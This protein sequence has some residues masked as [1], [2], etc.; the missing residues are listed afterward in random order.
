[1]D[2][3]SSHSIAT[4][5]ECFTGLCCKSN[6]FCLM[7]FFFFSTEET[8]FDIFYALFSPF[9]PPFLLPLYWKTTTTK[10]TKTQT[11]CVKSLRNLYLYNGLFILLSLKPLERQQ[12][13]KCRVWSWC[14]I[15]SEGFLT[16]CLLPPGL[17]LYKDSSIF[18]VG[19]WSIMLVSYNWHTTHTL[20]E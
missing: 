18:V 14:W 20:K 13:Q 7:L 12:F 19:F 3:I 6:L 15:C 2:L 5:N 8:F 9:L 10:K 16:P 17:S 1:M 4:V 11:T